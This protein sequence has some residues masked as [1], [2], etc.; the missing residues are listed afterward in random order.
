M[1][2]IYTG[3]TCII[4]HC[5]D[6]LYYDSIK[7][8]L[9]YLLFL[10]WAMWPMGLLLLYHFVKCTYIIE[11]SC[12]ILTLQSIYIICSFRFRIFALNFKDL[13]LHFIVY[14]YLT[15]HSW[16]WHSEILI[17]KRACS[18]SDKS[19]KEWIHALVLW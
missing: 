13:C 12:Q 18:I 11:K 7:L 16:N 15:T 9:S 6:S 4:V 2:F 19:P 17:L 14:N 1:D 10:R 5:P 8:I 3:S